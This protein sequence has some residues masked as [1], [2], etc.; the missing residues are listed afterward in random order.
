MVVKERKKL[1]IAFIGIFIIIAASV[2]SK[3]LK[4]LD[5]IWNYNSALNV[6]NGLLP[7]KDFNII[8]T[9]FS[10]FFLSLFLKIF[11]DELII[12]RLLAIILCFFIVILFHKVLKK[13]RINN[14]LIIYSTILIAIIYSRIFFYEYN[15]LNLFFIMLLIFLELCNKK[16]KK[17]N[18]LIGLVAGLTFVTKQTTGLFVIFSCIINQFLSNN[19]KINSNL[20]FRLFGILI[21]CFSF[22]FYCTS[23]NLW[24]DFLDYAILGVKTFTNHIPYIELFKSQDIVLILLTIAIPITIIISFIILIKNKDKNILVLL[25]YGLASFSIIYPIADKIHFL[26]GSLPLICCLIYIVN[27]Y[28]KPKNIYITIFLKFFILFVFLMFCLIS[29]VNLV[30]YFKDCQ[31]YQKLNHFRYIENKNNEIK[32]LNNYILKQE[33][34]GFNVYILDASAAIYMIPINHYTKDFDMFLK[35]NFGKTGEKGQI[36][37][38]KK[39][40]NCLFLIKNEKFDRNWQNPE[41]VRKYII[42][43]LTKK[44]EIAYFDVYQK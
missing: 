37:K 13:L 24:N 19:K 18:F 29:L 1:V 14:Q 23:N 40:N 8:T 12:V 33:K 20:I 6:L 44:E 34:S 22:C 2:L 41:L 3:P 7:Y 28:V 10:S 25:T 4:N 15:F 27:Y 21:P 9:P 42:N 43:N 39:C 30:N 31:K 5:E 16:K 32:K 26:T 38:I 36:K 11:G 17:V 35:G